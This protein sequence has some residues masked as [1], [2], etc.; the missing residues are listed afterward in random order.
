MTSRHRANSFWAALQSLRTRSAAAV[1]LVEF[2]R[3]TTGQAPAFDGIHAWL[4]DA[5]AE[6]AGNRHVMLARRTHGL[7]ESKRFD[8]L[9]VAERTMAGH[10]RIFHPEHDDRHRC[11]AQK[12]CAGSVA[13][14]KTPTPL[15]TVSA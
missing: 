13:D 10:L 9:R 3:V 15:A 14:G 11:L 1:A 6:L 12:Q 7:G 2:V 4:A 5:A 8:Q